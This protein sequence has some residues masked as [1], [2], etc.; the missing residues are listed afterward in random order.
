MRKAL[1]ELQKFTAAFKTDRVLKTGGEPEQA[2]GDGWDSTKFHARY[3]LKHSDSRSDTELDDRPAVR[4]RIA[5]WA[6]PARLDAKKRRQREEEERLRDE[7]F[8]A[9]T[10]EDRLDKRGI[11]DFYDVERE[12]LEDWANRIRAA[13][14]QLS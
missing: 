14:D 12:D 10:E 2:V 7:E 4:R 8:R 1:E 13:L 5:E 9:L 3:C 6:I 11:E